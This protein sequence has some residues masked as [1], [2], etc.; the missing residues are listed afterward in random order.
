[1]ASK[2]S[3]WRILKEQRERQAN[4]SKPVLTG[5]IVRGAGVASVNGLYFPDPNAHH[6]FGM[7]QGYRQERGS[8]TLEYYALTGHWFLT[9]RYSAVAYYS[10]R[11]TR[12]NDTSL[13]E[14]VTPTPPL[15][16]WVVAQGTDPVPSFAPTAQKPT[17][18]TWNTPPPSPPRAMQ[19]PQNQGRARS[20]RQ[21]R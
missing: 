13:Y 1:M 20:R 2:D 21:G 12:V 3:K 18:R 19:S 4:E 8:G 9:E 5:F 17:A 15:S 14:T 7:S 11:T 16:G 10:V 6:N